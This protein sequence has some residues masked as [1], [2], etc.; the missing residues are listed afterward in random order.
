MPVN[1]RDDTLATNKCT[2]PAVSRYA[3]WHARRNGTCHVST[4][5]ANDAA[6][7]ACQL[8]TANVFASC[9]TLSSIQDIR[10]SDELPSMDAPL[11]IGR[12]DGDDVDEHLGRSAEGQTADVCGDKVD[13]C[14]RHGNEAIVSVDNALIVKLSA[15][16]HVP[17][18][19]DAGKHLQE[20]K[21]CVKKDMIVLYVNAWKVLMMPQIVTMAAVW[22]MHRTLEYTL[23]NEMCTGQHPQAT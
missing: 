20:S 18:C 7:P 15:V 11:A 12:A 9:L 3:L 13:E 22:L 19:R 4:S 8:S 6:R 10:V 16:H 17:V 14:I 21:E 23:E 1:V 2:N 5:W